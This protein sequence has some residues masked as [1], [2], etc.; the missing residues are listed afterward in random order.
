MPKAAQDTFCDIYTPHIL[1]LTGAL[2]TWEPLSEDDLE[3]IWNE[4][5]GGVT[6]VKPKLL[7]HAVCF[8]L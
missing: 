7:E 2:P 6:V 4:V 1:D 5:Y 8:F 3:K